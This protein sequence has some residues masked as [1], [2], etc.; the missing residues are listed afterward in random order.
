M[1][2]HAAYVH[3]PFCE[4][5]CYYCDFNKVFLKN[6]PVAEYL[7]ALEREI[8]LT[9]Q[10][11]PTD[12]LETIFIGGG[13]PT[14]LNEDQMQRLMDIIKKH[15]LPLTD[16]TLEYTVESNPDGVSPEKL[17]IMKAGGVNRVSFGV[18]SFDDGLLERIGRTHRE[19]KVAET[20]EHAAKRFD[21]ISVDL[22]FGLPN[23][24]LEQ[25]RYDV[26]RAL[27]L[28]ITHISS[29]SLIL[30]PHTVFA[31]QERKGKLPLPTQDL[32][33]DMYRLMIETIEAGGLHQYEISNF[34]LP[35]RE[36][37]HNRV[38]WEN[39][40]YYG[41]GAGSHSYINKTRRANIAPIPHYIKAEGLPVR[42][43]TP[44]T[45]VERMEEEMFLGLRMKEGVSEQHFEAKYG[46]SLD[47]VFGQTIA[48]LLP[49]G[50]VER[51]ATHIRLT[52]A[53]VPLANE[54][55]AEFIGEAEIEEQKTDQA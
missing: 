49:R 1:T 47:Q 39:D 34:S 33:A 3:I 42:N 4:H 26:E 41:F 52:D 35:G 5:I 54:V 55:F 32:E 16:D 18:Q 25:V 50:L 9:L 30:E 24:T 23:Q 38:Y 40:E 46:Y 45:E 13:T 53:G 37:R 6:Q 29:Y 31:I 11:Y 36:S 15:L 21:N 20:L 14:A 22:M 2:P 44:L 10:Q 7:D 51:T 28:P 8:E 27:R 17:D 48:K 43:E 12:R 19:A